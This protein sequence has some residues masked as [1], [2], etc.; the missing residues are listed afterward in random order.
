MNLMTRR[1]HF[2][3]LA[4]VVAAF[5]G[6]LLLAHQ[7]AAATAVGTGV[8]AAM[9]E[10][11]HHVSLE[12]DREPTNQ[13]LA[14]CRYGAT[15]IETHVDEAQVAVVS[16]LGAGWYLTFTT[17]EPDTKPANG[18]EFA[19]I[20]YTTQKKNA[21]GEY[22][23]GYNTTPPLDSDLAYTIRTHPNHLWIVGNEVDRGPQPGY[24]HGGQG[25]MY[26][27]MYAVAY[28][29]VYHFIKRHDPT[30]RVAI[31]PLV[32]VTPGRL[33]YLDMVWDAYLQRYGTPMPVDVWNMHL[34]ILPEV[35]PDGITPNNIANVALGTDPRLGKRVS[36]GRPEDCPSPD[37]Y[38]FAEHD[39]MS[40]FAQQ[41]Q[42]MRQ[43]MKRHGEQNKPLILTEYSLLY[44]YIDDGGGSC[45]LMDE[46]GRCFTPARV[47]EFMRKSFD[48]L[49]AARDPNLGYPL[50]NNRL[51][52]Q[53]MWF[54]VHA[55][56]EGSASNLVEE[57]LQTL[58]QMGQTFRNYVFAETPTRN[59]VIE[60]VKNAV[61][62]S[63]SGTA[64][65]DLA[66]TFRNNGSTAVQQSFTVTFYEDALLTRPIGSATVSPPLG[67]CATNSKTV[68]VKWQ[69][70]TP[71]VHQYWVH[72]DSNDR[73]QETPPTSTDNIASALVYVDAERALLPMVRR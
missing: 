16:R 29:D 47:S 35:E 26:P 56:A 67:G 70:L 13:D 3:L 6:V 59:L 7:V 15:P 54:A 71:G 31:S 64:T 51:V 5:V 58:T 49:N 72:V 55:E 57:D 50:D 73:I 20:I 61:V 38:C 24:A 37:V 62:A 45:F 4:V 65:A 14:N 27:N 43:W 52:Q 22:L 23:P 36:N 1:T 19:H 41:V 12:K 53:W 25:D 42:N 30:A 66:V 48:Y 40:I 44:P 18:A 46:N 2:L 32:Q 34:Y 33:Q 63:N 8:E 21:A 11:A 17:E 69:G 68:S 60:R 39:D 28:H 9:L 10:S